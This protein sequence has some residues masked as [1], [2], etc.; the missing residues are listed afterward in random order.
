MAYG[1]VRTDLLKKTNRLYSLKHD[2]LEFENGS[3]VV[4][5]KYLPGKREVRQALV[6]TADHVATAS[7]ALVDAPVVNYEEQRSTDA[8]LENFTNVAGLAF[9]SRELVV[10]DIFSIS[11]D[12]LDGDA[13]EDAVVTAKAGSTQFQIA[14][15]EEG[16]KF[17]GRVV[18]K[19]KFGT[20][21]YVGQAG[22]VGR[23]TELVVIEVVSN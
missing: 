3:A 13:T 23:V 9:R 4:V 12:R 16:A 18:G 8:A 14:E 6:P 17:V 15:S 20:Q 21:A 1:V 11:P 22:A 19:E 7:I 10:G 5:G 2:T